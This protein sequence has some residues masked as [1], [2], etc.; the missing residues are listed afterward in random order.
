MGYYLPPKSYLRPKPR[1]NTTQK[2]IAIS[3][4]SITIIAAFVIFTT[5]HFT[6]SKSAQAEEVSE[7]KPTDAIIPAPLTN[8]NLATSEKTQQIELNFPVI[9]AYF[10]VLKNAHSLDV[11]WSTSVEYKNEF[12]TIEKSEN[13]GGFYE[14][15]CVDSKKNHEL[16][17]DYSYTDDVMSDGVVFYRLKQTSSNERSTYIALE[18]TEFNNEDSSLSLYIENVG[19]LP[20]DKYFNIH[21]YSSRPGGISVELFDKGGKNIYKTYTE[22]NEGYNTC[23]F[24]E[25]AKLTDDEYTL[26]ISNSSGA[27]IKRI[28]KRV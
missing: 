6:D 10:K 7:K 12:F 13:G 4:A 2:I 26:R 24:I 22:S 5:L 23:K 11:K 28:K 19:P 21:Y 16:S 14:I 8:S 9:L 20:F 18:K 15:G 17:N 27:Y 25:G 3:T 1:V